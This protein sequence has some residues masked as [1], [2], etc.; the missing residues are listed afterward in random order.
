MSTIAA[1][2]SVATDNL[3]ALLRSSS[4]TSPDAS[5][6]A[7][8]APAS[9]GT[10]SVHAGP[11]TVVDLS[12]SAKATLAKA[13]WDQVAADRLQSF[14]E[15]HRVNGNATGSK[16]AETDSLQNIL[17]ANAQPAVTQTTTGSSKIEAIVAQITTAAATEPQP[18]QTFTPTK[19]LSNSVTYGGFTLTLATNA[20]T[21]YYGIELSGDGVQAFNKHFGP[22]AGAGGSDGLPPGVGISIGTNGNNEGED[23]ITITR[24]VATATSAAS[25]SSAGSISTSSLDAQSSSITFLVNYA[26]GQI[27]VAQSSAALSARSTQVGAPGSRLSTLA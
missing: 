6:S 21:Q 22:S 25:S 2:N 1:T 16:T 11:V 13:K 10:S 9:P 12:D 4:A 17:D 18:F 27:S 14:V 3:L 8:G 26:T 20:S 7:T 23:A 15:A 19:S 24:N 5:P